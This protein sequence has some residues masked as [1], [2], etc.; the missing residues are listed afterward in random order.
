VASD[1]TSNTARAE[2]PL[3]AIAYEAGC[4]PSKSSDQVHICVSC[5]KV[6]NLPHL[7]DNSL[8]YKCSSP[9]SIMGIEISSHKIHN[10]Q[11]YI[12]C[13]VVPL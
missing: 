8:H 4:I 1:D 11:N 6:R 3:S 2:V 5:N 13:M 12:G 9:N 10:Q 7:K